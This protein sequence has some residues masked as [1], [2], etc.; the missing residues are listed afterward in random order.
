MVVA[1]ICDP[2][3]ETIVVCDTVLN[4][5]EFV[6]GVDMFVNS[7][8]TAATPADMK[9]VKSSIPRDGL[10]TIQYLC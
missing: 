8:G 1:R 10:S 9:R 2:L 7:C 4:F 6:L 3:L 5:A